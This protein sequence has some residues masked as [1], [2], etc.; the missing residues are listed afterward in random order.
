MCVC[1]VRVLVST[2]A[3]AAAHQESQHEGP[4]V[5]DG[6]GEGAQQVTAAL[7]LLPQVA[8]RGAAG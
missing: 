4:H 6:A 2:D 7:P 1:N 5:P 8:G 3:A